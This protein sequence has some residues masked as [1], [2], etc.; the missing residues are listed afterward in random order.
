ML[1]VC[2][3]LSSW[4]NVSPFLKHQWYTWQNSLLSFICFWSAH[5]VF[6]LTGKLIKCN[7]NKSHKTIVKNKW[8]KS[9]FT[10]IIYAFMVYKSIQK[11]LVVGTYMTLIL[12]ISFVNFKN[13]KHTLSLSL[14]SPPPQP[15]EN[16]TKQKHPFSSPV[17]N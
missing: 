17:Q 15:K 6:S 16:K 14:S 4:Y 1:K 7:K 10:K 3:L 12:F 11:L 2:G 8:K 13:L 9:A 5:C